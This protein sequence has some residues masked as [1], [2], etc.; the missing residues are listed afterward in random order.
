MC[1]S[2]LFYHVLGPAFHWSNIWLGGPSHMTSHYT[3]VFV[4]TLHDFGGILG[5][6][7]DTFFW[8]HYMILEVS[9]DD[10]ST[11]SFGLTT[12][13]W[14]CLRTTF[15]HFLLDSQ[16][17]FGGVLGRPLN[18]SFGLITWFWWCLWDG[19]W[20]LFLGSLHD[21]GD[22]LGRPLDTPF[23][24]ITWFWRC[25]G[26][27]F[28]H[29]FWAHYRNTIAGSS[30]W[31]RIFIFFEKIRFASQKTE[32]LNFCFLAKNKKNDLK[33]LRNTKRLQKLIYSIFVFM[34]S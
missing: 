1:L 15:G 28:G 12:W 21:F 18:T 29:F 33:W 4:T 19:L 34:S 16:H 20:T 14:R 8:T 23:G 24:L 30:P 5:R 25:L 2:Q 11:L 9:R 6:H 17:D 32:F 22:V 3:R 26:M 27:A 31:K 10:L 13:F 7:L